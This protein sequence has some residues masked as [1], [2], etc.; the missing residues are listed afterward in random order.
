M[1]AQTSRGRG[2]SRSQRRDFSLPR[3]PPAL[4]TARPAHPGGWCT[5]GSVTVSNCSLYAYCACSRHRCL[6]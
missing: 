5:D 4:P 1:M 3:T 6:R 2:T